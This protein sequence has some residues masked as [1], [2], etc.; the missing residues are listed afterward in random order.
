MPCPRPAVL[1]SAAAWLWLFLSAAGALADGGNGTVCLCTG[2]RC[3]PPC[4]V[5]GT[6]PPTTSPTQFPFC[7]QRPPAVGP[8]PWEQQPPASPRSGSGFPQD[9]GFLA[10]AA[11][12]PTR[13]PAAWLAVAAVCSALLLLLQQ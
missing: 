12:S 3:V 13:N 10:A 7:P 6:T 5:P 8:F 1:L 2:P 4:P 9:A 11:A